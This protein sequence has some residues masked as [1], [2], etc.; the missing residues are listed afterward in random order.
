MSDKGA[1]A[2]ANIFIGHVW[3]MYGVMWLILEHYW[4]G[5]AS[6]AMSL[7]MFYTRD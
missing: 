2:I 7:F 6:L 5:G 4:V 1:A 3:L